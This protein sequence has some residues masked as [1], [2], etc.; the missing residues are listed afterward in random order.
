MTLFGM[1]AI[2]LAAAVAGFYCGY[3]IGKSEE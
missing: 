2:V 3:Q 1:V